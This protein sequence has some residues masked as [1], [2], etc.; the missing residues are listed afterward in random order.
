MVKESSPWILGLLAVPFLFNA[1]PRLWS[2]QTATLPAEASSS[3]FSVELGSMDAELDVKGSW[4]ASLVGQTALEF[5]SE[6]VGFSSIQPFLLTQTPDLSLEFLLFKKFFVEARVA[7]DITQARYSFGY[8]GGEEETL[9]EVRAGNDGISFPELPFLSFGEGSYRSFGLAAKAATADFEGRAMIR[10]DQAT[11]ATKTFSGGAEVTDTVIGPQEFVRGRWFYVPADASNLVLYA[12]SASGGYAGSD[13]NNYR[14]LESGEYAFTSS[15]GFIALSR[16]SETSVVAAYD[17]SAG[18]VTIAGSSCLILYDPDTLT[19]PFNQVLCRYTTTADPDDSEAFVRDATSGLK[20]STYEVAIDSAGYAEVTQTGTAAT[21]LNASYALPFKSDADTAG[22]NWI[23]VTDLSDDGDFT[24]A[25]VATREIVVRSRS[26]VDSMTIDEDYIPGSVE[27]TR[28]AAP[29]YAFEVDADLHTVTLATPAGQYETIV[30][31]YLRESSERKSGSL[32]AG[33]GGI[34]T[35]GEGRSAWTAL[36]LRW[37]LPGVSYATA[38]ASNSGSITLTAGERD[39]EGSFQQRLAL[40]ASYTNEETSGRYRIEGMESSG[41]YDTSFRPTSSVTINESSFSALETTDSLLKAQFPTLVSALHSDGTS[42]KALELSD[43][44]SDWGAELVKVVTTPTYSSFGTFSFF[45]MT[46][47]ASGTLTLALDEGTGATNKAVEVEVPLSA[48]DGELGKWRRIVVKYGDLNIYVQDQEE[49]SLSPIATLST[50]FDASSTAARVRIRV[51][52]A[53]AGQ[54][55]W[56]DE[57]CLED[58]V[59]NAAL[60]VQGEL[61]YKGLGYAPLISG[62]A[63]AADLSAALH[64][65]S[66]ASGGASI[67]TSLGPL[68]VSL[69]GRGSATASGSTSM[70]AGHE[71]SFPAQSFP[72]RATDLFEFDPSTGAFGKKDGITAQAGEPRLTRAQA[73]NVLDSGLFP[74]TR[75]PLAGMG[76]GPERR[77]REAL[78]RSQGSE[79]LAPLRRARPHWRRLRHCLDR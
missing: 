51:E 63:I 27:V 29:E 3:L 44:A 31:S 18:S 23:Y 67:S 59:G 34:W 40:G 60:L 11:R 71:L 77:G 2:D 26:S 66:Y 55:V 32:A 72:L 20:D 49:G 7:D 13:G 53:A 41:S 42:Q 5:S 56:I 52:G 25:P 74:G 47:A 22:L 45:A 24:Y 30:V 50:A 37:S 76:R 14:K 4:E 39:A 79:P 68:G 33:L 35:L 58:S 78:A 64:E 17:G 61:S 28:D 73:A 65:E 10:Y 12:K 43:S 15:T 75:D 21:P 9:K 16:A 19:D 8:R 69:K 48:F 36:G 46:S 6:G 70:S 38:D 62:I 57:I 54:S 1:S